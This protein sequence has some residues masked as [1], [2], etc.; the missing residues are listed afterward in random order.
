MADDSKSL[1]APAAPTPASPLLGRGLAQEAIAQATAMTVQDAS[2]YL[3]QI[4]AISMAGM[5]VCMEKLLETKDPTYSQ[6]MQQINQSLQDASQ[7]FEK[8][9]SAA[10]NVMQKFSGNS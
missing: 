1:A 9:G 3:R 5:A 4:S 7:T 2:A 8:M 6:L 10:S